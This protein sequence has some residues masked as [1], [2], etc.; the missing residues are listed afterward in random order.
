MFTFTYEIVGELADKNAL[1]I[2][3]I[4]DDSTLSTR[5]VHLTLQESLYT[6]TSEE[7]AAALKLHIMTAAPQHEWKLET[8][9][10]NSEATAVFQSVLASN[11]SS[12]ITEED[13]AALEA[14]SPAGIANVNIVDPTEVV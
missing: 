6:G 8:A 13:L 4:P 2:K 7:I 11:G 12:A 14:L 5:N 3:Y 1:D 9:K 10:A